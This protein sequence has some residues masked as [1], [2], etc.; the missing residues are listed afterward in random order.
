MISEETSKHRIGYIKIDLKIPSN[1]LTFDFWKVLF[2]SHHAFIFGLTEDSWYLMFY[3]SGFL[4]SKHKF[5]LV[6]PASVVTSSHTF[7]HLEG[8]WFGQPG[9]LS[10]PNGST[11]DYLYPHS[12]WPKGSIHVFFFFELNWTISLYLGV[13]SN[14]LLISEN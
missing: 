2:L 10:L 14:Y 7:P 8:L 1:S 13:F 3:V 4:K 11:W 9:R 12:T 6:P 5:I